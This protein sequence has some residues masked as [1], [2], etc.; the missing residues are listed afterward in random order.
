MSPALSK[1]AHSPVRRVRKVA[2]KFW[3]KGTYGACSDQVEQE[4][5]RSQLEHRG[6]QIPRKRCLRDRKGTIGRF[7]KHY[8]STEELSRLA[9][10]QNS[11]TDLSITY[12]YVLS[13]I[14][15]RLV[16]LLPK[17]IA[18][19]SVT[20]AGLVFTVTG[21]LAVVF[22]AC[23]GGIR[24]IKS[25]AQW[26]L[27]AKLGLTGEPSNILKRSPNDSYVVSSLLSMPESCA[28]GSSARIAYGFSAFCL[29]MYQ[30]L[31]NLDGRQ[32]RRTGSSS[33]LGHFFDHGCDA[34]NVTFA[35]LTF[36]LTAQFGWSLWTTVL[37]LF[38]GMMPFFF[39]TLEEYFSGALVLREI[40]G[41]NE[42]LL[43]MQL[44]TWLTAI[45]GPAFWKRLVVVPVFPSSIF[46][47]HICLPS[48]V[49]SIL[50]SGG[51][52]EI[53]LSRSEWSMY[54]EML[55]NRRAV[56]LPLNRLF[57]LFT[58][59]PVLPTVISNFITIFRN[60]SQLSESQRKLRR[61]HL[62][63]LAVA[64]SFPFFT[65]AIAMI[66]WPLCSP[67]VVLA[68]GL[69]YHWL[70]GLTFFYIC[71]RLILAHLT[72]SVY[73]SAFP[74][75]IPLWA[76]FLN[77]LLGRPLPEFLVLLTSFLF[78]LFIVSRRVVG[79]VREISTFLGI[80]PFSIVGASSE[81]MHGT[82]SR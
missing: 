38:V 48:A 82:D 22:L 47:K 13:P 31:D 37:L 75:L 19:N 74:A 25:L 46:S 81:R 71:S 34:L 7:R 53:A 76:G 20:L 14:Y 78:I 17:S 60:G 73:G 5:R 21:H 59:L 55:R 64:Y 1:D 33:P 30:L 70:C 3:N 51:Y 77:A 62:V 10:Y 6:R 56:A 29:G 80:R 18:P 15:A 9:A 66:G 8:L 43:L 23:D 39:A 4:R 45:W 11:G 32:A 50:S 52:L 57:F 26:V 27:H 65:L 63:R 36:A 61:R 44:L 67:A 79:V 16:E 42:G 69:L 28:S 58:L 35:G 68:N 54:H 2:G 72:S 24:D 40:N 49:I 12:R 41:P